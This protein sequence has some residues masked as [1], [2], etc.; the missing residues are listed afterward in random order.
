MFVHT[1]PELMFSEE[2]YRF[3]ETAGTVDITVTF[4]AQ[5]ERN[6]TWT[7]T[8]VSITATGT[9]THTHPIH[10]SWVFKTSCVYIINFRK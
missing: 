1:A 2:V 3:N 9:V 4:E 5:V 10:A 8:S 7:L 6:H